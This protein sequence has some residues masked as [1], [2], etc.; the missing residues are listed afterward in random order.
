MK[1]KPFTICT[2]PLSKRTIQ[3]DNMIFDVIVAPEKDSSSATVTQAAT[4]E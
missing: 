1:I 2:K 4:M 3:Q